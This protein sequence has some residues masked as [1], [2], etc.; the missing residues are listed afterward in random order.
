MLVA[1]CLL[2]L[3]SRREQMLGRSFAS[4]SLL[5]KLPRS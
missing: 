1:R 4:V 3:P 2:G 5:A